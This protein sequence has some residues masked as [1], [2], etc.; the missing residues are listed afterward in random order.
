MKMVAKI[1]RIIKLILLFNVIY[2]IKIF[3]QNGSIGISPDKRD[4]VFYTNFLHE[5]DISWLWL[6]II[7]LIAFIFIFLE[8]FYKKH[9]YKIPKTFLFF[10]SFSLESKTIS[11]TDITRLILYSVLGLGLSVIML[12]FIFNSLFMIK[13]FWQVILFTFIF[14]IILNLLT[15]FILNY[16][17]SQKNISKNMLLTLLYFWAS[18]SQ[19]S[20]ILLFIL[21]FSSSKFLYS[22]ILILWLFLFIFAFVRK[23][24]IE[25]KFFSNAKFRIFHII[26]Y[27][28]IVE[29]SPFLFI[30]GNIKS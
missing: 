28:C 20:F 14:Q 12:Y 27:F 2:T 5:E 21:T 15:I 25:L 6:I 13:I 18:I 7:L 30:I 17:F 19:S 4:I 16:F 3:S 10:N 24:S 11:Y 26:L 29:F 8:Y 23:L 22:S 1:I 9:F